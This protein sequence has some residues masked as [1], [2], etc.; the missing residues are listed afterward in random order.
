MYK[1]IIILLHMHSSIFM[2]QPSLLCTAVSLEIKLQGMPIA[3][4]ESAILSAKLLETSVQVNSYEPIL[5]C[6]SHCPWSCS[7]WPPLTKQESH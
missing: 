2:A 1:H 6:L 3:M 4:V 7:A 5:N